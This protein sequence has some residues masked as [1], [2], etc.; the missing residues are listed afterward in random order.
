MSKKYD[1]H[2][3]DASE[4]TDEE[5]KAFSLE[6]ERSLET[7]CLNEI[8]RLRQSATFPKTKEG[9]QQLLDAA[10]LKACA[11]NLVGREVSALS[12]ARRKLRRLADEAISEGLTLD[13][14]TPEMQEAL[15]A[16]QPYVPGQLDPTALPYGQSVPL[17][18]VPHI[19]F[20]TAA[21]PLDWRWMNAMGRREL[22][23]QN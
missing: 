5:L 12:M 23:P 6:Y 19:T 1:P 20:S 15:R 9:R 17:S 7:D 4:L 13:V 21:L 10:W 18:E 16:W 8:A 2:R 3:P 22:A 11:N 14:Y